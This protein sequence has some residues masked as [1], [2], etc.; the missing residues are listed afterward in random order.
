MVCQTNGMMEDRTYHSIGLNHA[1]HTRKV[2]MMVYAYSWVKPL[3]H[4]VLPEEVIAKV[5]DDI[6]RQLPQ[7]FQIVL[8]GTRRGATGARETCPDDVLSQSFILSG[9][10]EGVRGESAYWSMYVET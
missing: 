4:D 5:Q 9:I 10:S 6:G 3:D 7:L 1:S 2:I 8:E